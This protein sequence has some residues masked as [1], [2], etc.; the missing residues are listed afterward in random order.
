MPNETFT[1]RSPMPVSAEELYAWH[2]R[3][4]AFQRLQ[5]P[6]EDAR[7]IK[8]EGTFGKDGF[9]ITIRTRTVG[10]LRGTWVADAFDFQPGLRFQD[11]ALEGPFASWHHTHLMVPGDAGTSVLEDTIE[12]RLPLG[13]AGRALAGGIVRE[14]LA[15]M[16]AY[17]HFITASDLRRHAKFAHKPRLT[18]AVTGS[19]GLIGS[20]LVPFLTTGGHQVVRLLTG[21]ATPPY[22]DGT[23][24]VAW[25]PDQPLATDT[26]DGVDAVIHLAGDNVAEGRWTDAKKQKILDSRTGPTRAIAQS[27]AALPLDRRPKVFVCASAVGF[28]GNRGEEELTEG[29]PAG[30]G[31]FPQVA[32]VWEDACVPAQDA[33]VRTAYM[34]IGVAISPKS[35]ALGKQLLPFKMGVGAV[36]GDGKQWVPW[37][38]VNDVVGAI[39]HTLMSDEI[40]G[41]VNTVGPNP[42]TNRTF[43]KTLGRVLSRPA[44]FWLPGVALR[45]VFGGVADDALLASMKARPAKLAT[46]G[47]TFDHPDLEP[48]LRFLLGR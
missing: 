42:V 30:E 2:A 9:R 25:K 11:R 14:R 20:E 17:R 28:Y 32:K 39:Y 29:S 18:I 41:P 40:R 23:K 35:G 33:G 5:P 38:T 43:T 44:F 45:A 10:P 37:I 19:R 13:I 46:N 24:W 21:D 8:Q 26:F 4:L 7:I 31:F 22:D 27:I 34:R 48:A 3:P 12:Y 36:L 15:A 47:F 16:F 6:W 1:L